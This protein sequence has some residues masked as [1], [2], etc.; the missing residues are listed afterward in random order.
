MNVGP[1]FPADLSDDVQ[2]PT[3][4]SFLGSGLRDH[5][6]VGGRIR[7]QAQQFGDH[8]APLDLA[9]GGRGQIALPHVNRLHAFPEG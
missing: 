8:V 5:A 4:S 2:Q 6:S 3:N 9:R 1:R 7:F